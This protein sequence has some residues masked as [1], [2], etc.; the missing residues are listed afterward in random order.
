MTS[1]ALLPESPPPLTYEQARLDQFR[2]YQRVDCPGSLLANIAFDFHEHLMDCGED[3]FQAM[4]ARLS[5]DEVD[6][7]DHPRRWLRRCVAPSILSR[8]RKR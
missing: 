4:M 6:V 5:Y 2:R 3:G 1:P 8:I 7:F